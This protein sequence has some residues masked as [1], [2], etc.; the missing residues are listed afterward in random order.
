MNASPSVS[1][2]S[3]SQ[4]CTH[5]STLNR[6]IFPKFPAASAFLIQKKYWPSLP[7]KCVRECIRAMLPG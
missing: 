5:W 6:T 4:V 1:S 7:R 2:A 3:R